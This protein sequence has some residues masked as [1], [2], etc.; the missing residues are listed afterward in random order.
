[1]KGRTILWAGAALLLAACDTASRSETEQTQA[2]P[3]V[4]TIMVR[5][6]V[7]KYKPQP[8]PREVMRTIV[9]CGIHAPNGMN[10]QPWEV[11]V[12]D[13]PE[14][15]EGVTA[16]QLEEMDPE[17][18]EAMTGE[19]FRNM[20]RNAPT[21]VFIANK[22]DGS[23]QID[24]GLMGGNMI[25]AARSMGIG[26]VCLGGPV[27]FM[28]SEKAADYLRRLGFSEGYSLLYAIGFGYPDEEP[29]A[30][31]RD[32]SKVVFVD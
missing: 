29:E 8:V 31:P 25:L 28:R 7:R 19:G 14:F 11:R 10:A 20:F 21:V 16:L 9:E 2:N 17:R 24:C 22:A 30:K 4:E 5:R 26:S 12:V 13:D 15:L 3:V 23:G 18:R 1:M 6:S 32:A 27:A